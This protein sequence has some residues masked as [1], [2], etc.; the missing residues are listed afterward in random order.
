MSASKIPDHEKEQLMAITSTHAAKIVKNRFA[1]RLEEEL[2]ELVNEQFS[3]PE[4]KF[5]YQTPLTMKRAQFHTVQMRFYTL[6]RRDCWAYVQARAPLDVKQAIWHH[7]E[8]EL[9]S[10]S[11]TGVDH[12]TMVGREAVA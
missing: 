11:R 1:E 6:N 4:F 3:S 5:L 7:E 10:D 9:I 12:I 2:D 8:D